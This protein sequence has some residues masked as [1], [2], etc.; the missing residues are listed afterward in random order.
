MVPWQGWAGPRLRPG[1]L[2][3]AR[4]LGQPQGLPW[5]IVPGVRGGGF[6]LVPART[7]VAVKGQWGM[8]PLMVSCAPLW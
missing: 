1:A 3:R 6:G 2:A 5:P 7:G 4:R 8:D